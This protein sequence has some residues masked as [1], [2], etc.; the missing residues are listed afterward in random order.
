MRGREKV[1]QLKLLAISNLYPPNHL[2]GYELGC[3]D[4]VDALR[5][6]GHEVTVLTSRHGL[7]APRVEG[8]V[9][10]C[11]GFR[12]DQAGGS[13]AAIFRREWEDQRTLARLI[14]D[15]HPDLVYAFSFYGI[16][17]ALLL[18]AQR[19]GR[20]IVYAFSAEWLE[21]GCGGD[22]WLSLWCGEAS[23]PLKRPLKR[24]ARRLVDPVVPTGLLPID[25]RHAYFTSQRLRELYFAKGF[26][27][28]D[29]EVIHWGVDLARF[30]PTERRGADNVLRLLFAGRIA[31]VKGLHTAIQAMHLLKQEGA[32]GVVLDVAGPTQEPDYL[33][34]LQGQ[35]A[36]ASLQDTVRFLG[37]IPWQDMPGL[38]AAHDALVFPSIWEEPFSI[39][40]LEAMACGQVVVGTTTGG[41]AEVLEDGVNSLVFRP[42]DPVGLAQQVKRLFDMPLRRRIGMEA[43]RTVE[44]RFTASAMMD[45]IEMLLR[46]VAA[47]RTAS[48]VGGGEATGKADGRA[49]R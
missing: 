11:L 48:V 40:L 46:E 9:H 24:V 31:K 36:Q 30:H 16:S 38:Y 42:D 44:R 2:G 19:Q 5:K 12:P 20:A 22:P 10:R 34:M 17:K 25:V 39:G 47:R 3:A 8:H 18:A 32:A 21:P 23:A 37:E 43:R 45:R 41:S 14:A 15:F 26:P 13:R 49:M 33:S 28:Q 35:I 7:E 27:V 29:A 4:I 1:D 6:R